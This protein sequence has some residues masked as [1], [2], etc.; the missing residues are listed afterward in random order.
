MKACI[1]LYRSASPLLPS[2]SISNRQKVQSR[3]TGTAR[4]RDLW[5]PP[6]THHDTTGGLPQFLPHTPGLKPD[7]LLQL[8]DNAEKQFLQSTCCTCELTLLK[9]P[10]LT[11]YKLIT[12]T[13]MR[14][15]DWDVLLFPGESK[16]PIQEFD[17][18]C[19][20]L[21]QGMRRSS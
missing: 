8:L 11:H 6:S 4:A 10:L 3:T 19:Q 12:I 1:C 14:Y 21:E 2:G 16:I 13:S 9:H 20:V 7:F 15:Q 18:K 17:T 5:I